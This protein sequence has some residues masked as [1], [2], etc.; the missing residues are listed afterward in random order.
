MSQSNI[1]TGQYVHIAQTPVSIGARMLA[2]IIDI[3]I[4]GFYLLGMSILIDLLNVQVGEAGYFFGL[5]LPVFF[6]SF[7]MEVLNN[8]QSLGKMVMKIK[9]VKKDGSTPTLGDYF[10]RWLLQIIDVGLTI[11]PISIL[12]TKDKQRIGDLAAGTMVIQLH[13]YR[14]LQVSLDEFSYLERNYTPVYKQAEDLTLNQ[15]DVIQRTLNSDYTEERSYRIEKL[16]TKVHQAL[17]IP[18]DNTAHEKFLYTI[19][20][21]YQHFSLEVI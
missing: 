11:A 1:I 12:V 5:F 9:V 20:R 8:G 16:S 19:I 7:L 15:I 17:N 4:L 6:Y 2:Y 18:Y 21:D 10:M 13:N 14:K 3:A